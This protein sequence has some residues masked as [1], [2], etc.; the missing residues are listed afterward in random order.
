MERISEVLQDVSAKRGANKDEAIEKIRAILLPSFDFT[1]MARRSM[2]NHWQDLN[3]R[4]T[5]FVAAFSGFVE[6]SYMST[7]E[8][9]RGEKIVFLR[10]RVDRDLAEV[11]T[12][13]V[14]GGGDAL[15]VGYR[16]H[17]VEEQW[18]VYDVIVDGISLTTNFRSQFNRVLA[19]ASMDE[20]M[21]KLRAKAPGGPA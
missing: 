1:E 17:L 5:E 16:L 21:K 4:Q 6:G 10:E 19:T 20:L 9:Y 8:S 7:L 2:G 14:H 3:G 15:A 18:K 12:Q 11:D 13:V